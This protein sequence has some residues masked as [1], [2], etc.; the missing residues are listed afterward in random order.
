MEVV[1]V[2]GG[3]LRTTDISDSES[4]ASDDTTP[5]LAML[6]EERLLRTFAK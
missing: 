6:A 1:P 3:N 5:Q 4:C 2:W